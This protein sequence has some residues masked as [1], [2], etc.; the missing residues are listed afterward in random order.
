MNFLDFEISEGT[1]EE[2]AKYLVKTIGNEKRFVLTLNT[3]IADQYLHKPEYKNA[4]KKANYIIPDGFGIV[5]AIK[6]L[7]R[8]KI[9]RVPGIELMEYLCKEVS[10]K[11]QTRRIQNPLG[12]IALCGFD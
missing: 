2:H 3:L 9:P 11:D 10:Q 6:I 12:L 1:I 4:L 8:K 7:K 5:K